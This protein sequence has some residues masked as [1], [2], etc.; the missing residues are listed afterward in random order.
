MNQRHGGFGFIWDGVADSERHLIGCGV[1]HA[2]HLVGESKTFRRDSAGNYRGSETTI[3][4]DAFYSST[5][6]MMSQGLK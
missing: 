4:D 6:W 2:A 5:A 3:S 1:Q